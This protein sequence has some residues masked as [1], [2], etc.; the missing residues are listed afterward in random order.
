MASY[1][2]DGSAAANVEFPYQLI[3][4]PSG[5]IAFNEEATGRLFTDDLETIP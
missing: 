5:E 2:A 1:E 4:R 3:F